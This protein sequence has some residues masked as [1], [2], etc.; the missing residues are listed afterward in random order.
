V[1]FPSGCDLRSA[2]SGA[3][4][5]SIIR[6]WLK[7][8]IPQDLSLLTSQVIALVVS[9]DSTTICHFLSRS[10]ASEERSIVVNA[11]NTLMDTVTIKI[12]ADGSKRLCI[13][14][15]R[16]QPSD[17]HPLMVKYSAGCIETLRNYRT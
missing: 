17:V 14:F 10:I 11:R 16:A 8:K 3:A 9:I 4:A 12:P 13:H 7:N 6:Q 2:K 5:L 1:I 15:R